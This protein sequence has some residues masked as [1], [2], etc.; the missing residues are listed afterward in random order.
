MIRNTYQVFFH[1]T[2][3][4]F[5]L[6]YINE[7][8]ILDIFNISTKIQLHIKNVKITNLFAI[9]DFFGTPNSYWLTFEVLLVYFGN[10]K[11]DLKLCLHYKLRIIC[12]CL[13]KNIVFILKF[14]KKQFWFLYFRWSNNLISKLSFVTI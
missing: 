14:V 10:F 2:F 5:F 6:N 8:Y 3:F 9:K 13:K 11:T 7:F 4:F 12:S 1:L